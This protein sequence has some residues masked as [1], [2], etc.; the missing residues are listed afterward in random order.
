M[1]AFCEFISLEYLVVVNDA[2]TGL[3][4]KLQG[5]REQT[6][7]LIEEFGNT[8]ISTFCNFADTVQYQLNSFTRSFN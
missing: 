1:I 7:D 4:R 2:S 6:N 3:C 5:G 8:E